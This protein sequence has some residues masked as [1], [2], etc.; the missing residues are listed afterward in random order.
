RLGNEF[1]RLRPVVPLA[2]HPPHPS[3]R[4][5]AHRPPPGRLVPPP[6]AR[7]H[8]GGEVLLAFDAPAEVHLNHPREEGEVPLILHGGH[9]VHDP[10]PSVHGGTHR[11]TYAMNAGIACTVPVAFFWRGAL[12]GAWTG[13]RTSS[14]G[15]Q[16]PSPS[17]P[18]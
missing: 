17:A 16:S 4:R 3:D 13:S 7:R 9:A 6:V 18:T 12:T 14:S 11:R 8:E 15:S 10:L 5:E 1:V 2:P